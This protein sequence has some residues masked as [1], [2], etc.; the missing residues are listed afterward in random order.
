MRDRC[1]LGQ[2]VLAGVFEC[3]LPSDLV[4][5]SRLKQARSELAVLLLDAPDELGHRCLGEPVAF[6]S[7]T[8]VLLHAELVDPDLQGSEAGRDMALK[9][10]ISL[11]VTA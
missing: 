2:I 6:S 9:I 3:L 11:C 10:P 7:R 5:A 8:M 4:L 1:W